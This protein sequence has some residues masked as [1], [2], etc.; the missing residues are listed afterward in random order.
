MTHYWEEPILSSFLFLLIWS[1]NTGRK[2]QIAATYLEL[3]DDCSNTHDRGRL[4]G[5]HAGVTVERCQTLSVCVESVVVEGH[6]LARDFLEIGGH[7]CC[8]ALRSSVRQ[9]GAR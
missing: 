8:F 2:S 7:L 5:E 9:E 3:V 6:E 4:V 1:P